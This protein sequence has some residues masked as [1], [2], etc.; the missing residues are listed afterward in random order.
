MY[1]VPTPTRPSHFRNSLATNSD[2][3]SERICSGIPRHS[4][5]SAS[6]SIT[7]YFPNLLARR[8]AGHSGLFSNHRQHADR[9]SIVSHRT[10]EAV[11]PDV[12]RLLGS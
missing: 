11:A 5:T 1:N 10:H 4:I 8:I 9:S 7:S 6:A 12:I 3:L 2:P